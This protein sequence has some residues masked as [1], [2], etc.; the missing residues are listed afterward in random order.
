MT[1]KYKYYFYGSDDSTDI[2]VLISI[3]ANDMPIIQE[4]RKRFVKSI[5]QDNWNAN[6][7][8]V[9]NGIVTDTIYP[10]TW[11]DSVN[12]SLFYT[13]HL[14]NNIYPNP[15]LNPVKR[16]KLLVAFKALRTICSVIT[17]TE[18]RSVVKPVLNGKNIYDM[19]ELLYQIDFTKI[20]SF[21]QRNMKDEDIW[22]V[23]AF[24]IGQYISLENNE[25]EIYTKKDLIHYHPLLT[26]FIYRKNIDKNV[27]NMYK[28]IFLDILKSKDYIIN[29]DVLI[30]G[31]EKIQIKN[32]ISF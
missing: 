31:D 15:I 13:Y 26:N 6:L 27:L 1:I 12:N 24:Y 25:I 11:I 7:M 8:V 30:C 17:R 19:I 3:P 9:E 5:S 16:N 10:K 4:D 2:D 22:K 29:N 18:Y 21:N 32:E 14:H 20:S 28:I 23:I